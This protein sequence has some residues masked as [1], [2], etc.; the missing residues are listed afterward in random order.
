MTIMRN[1]AAAALQEAAAHLASGNHDGALRTLRLLIVQQPLHNAGFTVFADLCTL[2]RQWALL[3]D[4]CQ[5][6]LQYLPNDTET[7]CRYAQAE[8]GQQH[9][10]H[11][12]A[13]LEDVV[14]RTPEHAAA[15][16][17]LGRMLKRLARVDEACACF[18]RAV[19]AA[20]DNRIFQDSL[21]F[22]QLFSDT[23]LP[24][25]IA[26]AHRAWGTNF[27]PIPVPDTA[28]KPTGRIT[29]GYLSPDFREHSVASFIEPVLRHHDRQRFR[30]IC[31]QCGPEQDGT[32]QR[33][34]SMVEQW[35]NITDLDDAAA[36]DVI[37][38]DGVTI[39]VDLAGHTAWNRLP[40]LALRPAP[41]Q[42][43]WIGYP[44]STG[45]T[46]ID[47]RITDAVADPPGTAES[48]HT[49]HLARL[50]GCFLCYSPPGDAPQ[51]AGYLPMQENNALT[52]GCF[53]NLAKITPAL[54]DCWRKLLEQIPQSRLLLKG[55][56]FDDPA[57]RSALL[58]Q[59]ALPEN[60]VLTCG[61]TPDRTSH[62]SLYNQ[63]DIAL[64]T[65]PYNGT[66]TTCEALWMGVP[67]ITL[68][69]AHHASRVGASLLAS[70]GLEFC[71]CHSAEE[72]I[73]RA[74]QL[75]G[76]LPLLRT[77]RTD[78]R[79]M[80]SASPLLDGIGFTRR[81]ELLYQQALTDSMKTA[82]C[83]AP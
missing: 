4:I 53:N 41:L 68:A 15:W 1:D 36:Y 21:L 47:Y 55:E 69:G 74:I 82:G 63:V 30:I 14:K 20:P 48:L 70:A 73:Q 16:H 2:L 83:R 67:V 32:T 25:E 75:A 27:P 80:L 6:R 77:L 46:Q 78:L 8:L 28:W 45:L 24:E 17:E 9:Y 58:K 34:C 44:H 72:Y 56:A 60:R 64:D 43:T 50:P 10:L 57:A 12:I 52:F 39:L 49:E 22:T 35:R 61:W 37:I 51:P 26:A 62:L 29:V 79:A 42:M 66:T 81:L 33:L 7:C 18:R 76:N 54:L 38:R 3:S 40:L 65:W 13:L 5:Q 71:V 31:Y 23:C 59:F 11:A 19:T